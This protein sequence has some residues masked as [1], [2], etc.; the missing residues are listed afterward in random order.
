MNPEI[1]FYKQMIEMNLDLVEVCKNNSDISNDPFWRESQRITLEA[2]IN[3]AEHQ[4]G[5]IE[6]KEELQNIYLKLSA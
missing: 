1:S 5:I 4:I 3:E 2:R 6:L